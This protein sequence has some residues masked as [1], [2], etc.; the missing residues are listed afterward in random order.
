MLG[1]LAFA[2]VVT[3][4]LTVPAAARDVKISGT[5][6]VDDIAIHCMNNGGTFFNG[7]HGGYGCAGSGGGTVTCS[8]K[9]K[10]TGTVSRATGKGGKGRGIAG[11]VNQLNRSKSVGNTHH[12]VQKITHHPVQKGVTIKHTNNNSS[13]HDD[14]SSHSAK[15][16]GMHQ[17]RGR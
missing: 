2:F 11:M 3:A 10:C 12:P 15:G 16:G 8:N 17:G 5:H 6:S 14:S 13:S 9:G 7:P 1:R 4:I